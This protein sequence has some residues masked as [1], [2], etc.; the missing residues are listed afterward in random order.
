MKKMQK[1][2]TFLYYPAVFLVALLL[3]CLANV[4]ISFYPLNAHTFGYG[5]LTFLIVFFIVAPCVIAAA[6]RFSLLKW[7][8]DPFVASIYPLLIM[9]W[10][11]SNTMLQTPDFATAIS[12][13]IEKLID[14][15]SIFSLA[16]ILII[17]YIFVLA[18]SYSVA[19]VKG[20]SIG[21]KLLGKLIK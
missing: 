14:I 20:E 17:S 6:S 7:R 16:P 10:V 3:V 2:F 4:I 19:R 12:R 5:L 15:S 8:F 13:F 18:C 21:F 11:F 1:L 9:I